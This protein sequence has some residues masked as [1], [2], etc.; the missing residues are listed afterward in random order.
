[1]TAAARAYYDIRIWSA[2]FALLNYVVLGAVIGRG[3][4]DLGLLLQV[5]INLSNIALNVTLVAGFG[6]GVRGSA[7]GTR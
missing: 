5:L 1:M 7:F 4:T 6:Y 2:P 3:R